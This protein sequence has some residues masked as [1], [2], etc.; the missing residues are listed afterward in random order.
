[1]KIMKKLRAKGSSGETLVEIMVSGLLFL[2]LMAVMQGAISFCSSA[3]QKSGQLR[4]TNAEICN[5]LRR[6]ENTPG[7]VNGSAEMAFRAVAADGT[8]GNQ[9]FTIPVELEERSVTADGKTAV[10]YSFA[11]GSTGGGGP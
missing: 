8:V 4:K 5:T 1:M 3:Q 9:V 11:P 10:F 7:T 6:S 2:L